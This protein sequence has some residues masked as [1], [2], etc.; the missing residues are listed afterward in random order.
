MKFS[1]N[2]SSTGERK[3]SLGGE[4]NIQQPV[5]IEAARSQRSPFKSNKSC[6][7]PFLY[8]QFASESTFRQSP[9]VIGGACPRVPAQSHLAG[10]MARGDVTST[11]GAAN[12]HIRRKLIAAQKFL[13]FQIP[14][15]AERECGGVAT[16]SNI[17]GIR[18][19]L[20]D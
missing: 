17:C 15:H 8:Q 10:A 18:F 11:V 14:W 16:F 1:Q 9:R 2:F 19:G 12:R 6:T 13:F 7:K 4:F 3:K 20:C 5:C